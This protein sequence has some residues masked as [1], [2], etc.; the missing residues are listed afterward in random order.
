[1]PSGSDVFAYYPREDE[2]TA[3]PTVRDTESLGASYDRYL[4]NGV[5]F[6][7][8]FLPW[9]LTSCWQLTLKFYCRFLLMVLVSLLG[10]WVE[11]LITNLLMIDE[12]SVSEAWMVGVLDMVAEGL[13]LHFLQMLQILYLWRASL[14]TV[15]AGKSLV[16]F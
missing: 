3:H 16:S 15:H 11:E 14:L 12:S 4:R 5:F 1:M 2:G 6:M 8:A 10:L 7:N 13:N 9:V